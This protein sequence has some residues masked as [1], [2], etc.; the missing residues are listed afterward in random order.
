M[1][2]YN[3]SMTDLQPE[4]MK[5]CPYCGKMTS[6]EANFCWWCTRELVARPEHPEEPPRRTRLLTWVLLGLL[7]LIVVLFLLLFP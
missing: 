2:R 4:G 6:I 3:R 1:R 7:V 5:P